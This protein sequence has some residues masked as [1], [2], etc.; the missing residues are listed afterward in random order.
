MVE[1][2]S[3]KG[4]VV[5]LIADSIC[6]TQ[7]MRTYEL[8][9]M[10]FF[11]SEIM[12]HKLLS[13][14]AASSRAIPYKRMIELTQENPAIPTKWGVNESGMKA[15][16]FLNER[17]SEAATAIWLAARDAMIHHSNV[18]NDMKVHKQTI[19]RLNEPW[20]IMKVVLSGTEFEN[21]FW[22]RNHSDAQPEFEMLASMMYEAGKASTPMEL[23]PGEWHLPYID[24]VRN[25]SGELEY[26]SEGGQLT[27]E[28]ALKVST[29]CCAQAS[30]R[31]LDTST[32]KG[33]TIYDNLVGSDRKHASPFEHQATPMDL[34][35]LDLNDRELTI[36]H[37][38]NWQIGV[39][40]FDNRGK[41]WSGNLCG[42]VQHR[43]LLPGEA[44]W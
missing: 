2:D 39:S 41:F 27:L 29:S 42:W 12:T 30:Y 28:Q 37:P 3:K 44:V 33:D 25:S 15:S 18:L 5:K 6:G 38:K 4:I 11:H 14:N 7:R 9:Y 26:F 23:K 40:H 8:Q 22:L 13:K 1:L 17:E 32:E 31:R 36:P 43:K 24:V 10:R 19:N 34:Q 21:F 20:Q 16:Q 35:E